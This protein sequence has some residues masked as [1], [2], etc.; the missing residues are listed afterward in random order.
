MPARLSLP[1]HTA[2]AE[3]LR[4]EIGTGEYP[5]GSPLPSEARLSDRFQVSRGTIRQA[6]GALRTEGL[7]VGGRGRAPVVRRPGLSQSFDQLVSFTAWA[8]QLGRTPSAR[9]LELARRPADP[10]SAEQLDLDP[11]TPV[12]QYRR[13]RMLDG[14]PVMIERTTMIESVGRLLLDCDLDAGSVYA[15]LGA[16]GV[17]FSEA[18]QT[19]AAIAAGADDAA[20]LGIAR[21]APLLE[22]RRRA[23]DPEGRS[24]EWAHDRYRGDAFEITV[25]NQHTLPRSGVALRPVPLPGVRAAR[26]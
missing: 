23:L 20:L 16:R 1:R 22:V 7:I 15:Q 11:G 26:R 12:F 13:L 21:R 6:V 17:V 5:E 24:I 10:E 8:R 25:H 2:I 19:I 3:V 4:E 18:H 14:E 9:A